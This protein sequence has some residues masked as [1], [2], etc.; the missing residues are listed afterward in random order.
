MEASVAP[1]A[2]AQNRLRP[3]EEGKARL[4]GECMGVSRGG[5]AGFQLNNQ[6]NAIPKAHKDG[7]RTNKRLFQLH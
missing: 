7:G 6:K 3:R 5:C 2:R 1:E 4:A